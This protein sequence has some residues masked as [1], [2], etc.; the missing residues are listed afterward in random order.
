MST[1]HK[2]RRCSFAL[3]DAQASLPAIINL[4]EI[5]LGDRCFRCFGGGRRLQRRDAGRGE[6][7]FRGRAARAAAFA[8][9]RLGYIASSR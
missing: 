4:R 9:D 1:K 5:A 7:T 8:F 2:T 3:L 6:A